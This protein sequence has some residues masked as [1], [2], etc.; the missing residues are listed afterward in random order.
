ML[1]P[2]IELN[3]CLICVRP[4]HHMQMHHH[5]VLPV[6]RPIINMCGWMDVCVCEGERER[7]RRERVRVNKDNDQYN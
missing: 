6:C 4:K 1:P 3:L 5:S 2:L 7:E